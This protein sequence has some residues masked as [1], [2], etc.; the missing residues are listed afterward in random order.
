MHSIGD[1]DNGTGAVAVR[2]GRKIARNED[3]PG[4]HGESVAA[5][6]VVVFGCEN[7]VV[8][9]AGD[10]FTK[11]PSATPYG[12]SGK[13]TWARGFAHRAGRSEVGPRC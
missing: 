12:R 5:G 8:K 11:I 1:P 9:F 6:E 13:L 10:R 2:D 4:V 7:G 3:C